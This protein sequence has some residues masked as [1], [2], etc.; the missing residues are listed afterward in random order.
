MRTTKR[1]DRFTRWWALAL[2]IVFMP[3]VLAALLLWS[4]AAVVLLSV[5]WLTWRP[6]GRYAIVVYSN[7][8]IWQEYFESRIIP[9]LGGRA[10]VLNWSERR[11]WRAALPVLLFQMFRG[12]R[13]FNPMAIVFEP[14]KRPRRFRFY[15]AFRAFKHGNSEE[16]ER[17]RAEFLRVLDDVAGPAA[18]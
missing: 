2:A 8:P 15:R 1:R 4:V 9:V 13:D 14:L 3:V 7:S 17:V 16:V 10:V 6:R 11:A 12:S 5:V 18:S